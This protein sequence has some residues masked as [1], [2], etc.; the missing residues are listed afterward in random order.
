VARPGLEPGTTT[1]SVVLPWSP[2]SRVFTGGLPL[3]S[4]PISCPG[5]LGLCVRFPRGYGPRRGSSPFSPRPLV[6]AELGSVPRNAWT[7]STVIL[8]GEITDAAA[9]QRSECVVLNKG[10]HVAEAIS[11]LDASLERMGEMQRKSRRLM[12]RSP[13]G[14]AHKPRSRTSYLNDAGAVRLVRVS[15]LQPPFARDL[16]VTRAASTTR[17]NAKPRRRVRS[18][19]RR[20]SCIRSK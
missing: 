18:M 3:F 6:R 4:P 5:F 20:S 15:E 11:A 19:T 9:A 2:N 14:R 16:P 7:L 10:P 13:P 1:F 8:G 12:R 17:G